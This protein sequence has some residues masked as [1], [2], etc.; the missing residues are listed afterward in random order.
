MVLVLNPVVE[1]KRWMIHIFYPTTEVEMR[2]RSIF[3][4]IGAPKM[5]TLPVYCRSGEIK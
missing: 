2:I 5:F 1:A 4:L 3:W